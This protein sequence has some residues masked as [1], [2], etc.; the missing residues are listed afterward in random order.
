VSAKIVKNN[1]LTAT[2]HNF[3]VADILQ[4]IGLPPAQ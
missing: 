4:Q 1:K 3:P 2:W